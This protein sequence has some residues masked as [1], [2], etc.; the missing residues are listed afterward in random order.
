MS[1]ANLN[2]P[3][4]EKQYGLPSGLLNAVMMA[5]SSGNPNA[6]SPKGALGAFQFMPETAKA[7]GVNPLDPQSSAVGAARMYGDLSKQFGGDVPSML[8]AYNWGSG[9]LTKKGLQNAP[10][11]TRDYIAKIMPKIGVQYADSG[12][13]MNDA[14]TLSPM[15]VRGSNGQKATLGVNAE[16]DIDYMYDPEIA[17]LQAQIA[18]LE[19]MP[20]ADT[21][22]IEKQIAELEA[23]PDKSP[24]LLE[25]IGEL[26]IPNQFLQGATFGMGDELQAGLAS[27]MGADYEQGLNVARGGLK[28]SAEANPVTAAVANMV[29]G[30]GSAILGGGALG[31][32]LSKIAPAT[33]STVGGALAANPIKA[34][35]GVGGVSGGLYG[36]GTGEGGAGERA[37]NAAISGVLGAGIGGAVPFVGKNIIEPIAKPTLSKIASK[38]GNKTSTVKSSGTAGNI[39]EA[40][41]NITEQP[42]SSVLPPAA[43][44]T[45]KGN[46]LNLPKGVIDKDVNALRVQEEARQGILGQPAQ[47]AIKKIDETITGD[48]KSATQ[49][50]IGK[51]TT[52]SPDDLL[53][54]GIDSFRKQYAA[55]KKVAGDLMKIRNDKIANAKIYKDYT[56]Q[57]LT[58]G[59]DDL[60]QSSDNAIF[61]QT[62]AAKPILEYK[63]IL[64]NITAPKDT[65]FARPLNFDS[66]QGWS[67]SVSKF[68]RDA[69]QG[70]REQEAAIANQMAGKYNDWLDNITKEAFKSGD[71]DLVD[72]IFKANR[73]YVDFKKTFG[74]N[75]AAGE[76]KI[77]EDILKKDA[78]TPDQIVGMTFGKS[79][80][81]KDTTNQLVGRM[82]KSVPEDMKPQ[83]VNDFR[84]GLIMRSYKDSL[85]ADGSLKMGTFANKL[86]DVHQSPVYKTHLSDPQYDAAMKGLYTDITSYVRALNDPTVRSTSGTGGAISRLLT[87]LL[88]NPVVSR[89]TAGVSTRLNELAQSAAKAGSRSELREIEK[90]F[91]Q[92]LDEA[93]NSTPTKWSTVA[94]V[95]TAAPLNPIE[96]KP[97]KVTI[98]PQD[99]LPEPEVNLP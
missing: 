88:D 23:M 84:A 9:N 99:K 1:L 47:Q 70:G 40:A 20:D 45:E 6:I 49:S 83:M 44:V 56:H 66:L 59:V 82:L 15:N 12:Q 95:S 64:D 37:E 78:L 60:L 68:A 24:S 27:L 10:K 74:T 26:D 13:I 92:G 8:A 33:A 61:A 18:E 36:F 77:L 85:N 58:K 4:L 96:N 54:R 72:S 16:G 39:E 87:K 41:A 90:Q 52:D 3:D 7:Y 91:F 46:V 50:L 76:S 80:S 98:T 63:Q 93:I 75:R 69:K 53:L 31:S 35:M 5:E 34:G 32:A 89:G 21:G 71:D 28:E 38:F 51:E 29:G 14:N 79:A 86:R 25:Q 43:I 67:A 94:P 30:A 55:D 48:I 81:G 11:E 62:T 57:T 2:L 97:L 19:A 73:N 42:V 22:D 17:D 65:K